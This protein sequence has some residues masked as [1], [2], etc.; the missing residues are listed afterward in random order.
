MEFKKQ[1]RSKT[2]KNKRI[3]FLN[4]WSLEIVEIKKNNEFSKQLNCKIIITKKN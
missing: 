1:L 4:Q 2:F 3:E